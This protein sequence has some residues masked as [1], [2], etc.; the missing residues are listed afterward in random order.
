MIQKAS[1]YF[2]AILLTFSVLICTQQ[3]AKAQ[4]FNYKV[5]SMYIYYFTKYVG[6]S[7]GLKHNEI[8]IGIIGDS[9]VIDEL[10]TLTGNKK[11]NGEVI[12]IKKIAVA[13]AAS[14]Q[15]IIISKSSIAQLKQVQ[16]E[17]K[18]QPVLIVTEKAGYINKGADISIY[19]DDEDNF[20]TKFE[21][22]KSNFQNKGLKVSRELLGLAENFN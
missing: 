12:V 19:I 13:E 6:W 20:K 15:I 22:N 9:P 4:T 3:K 2:L 16:E 18:N 14:C 1:G 10:K 8:T 7:A 17:I 5:N 11:V 21:L